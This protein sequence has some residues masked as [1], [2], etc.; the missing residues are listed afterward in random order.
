MLVSYTQDLKTETVPGTFT[1]T[2]NLPRR[3]YVVSL[4]PERPIGERHLWT[5]VDY[6][7]PSFY[8]VLF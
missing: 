1:V 7:V 3:E 8:P 5:T 6:R 4:W 2:N